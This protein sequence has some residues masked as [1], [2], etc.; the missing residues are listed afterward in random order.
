MK[1]ILYCYQALY[2]YSYN[3]T[4]HKDSPPHLFGEMIGL[5]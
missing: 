5:P 1:E 4:E 3:S 2:N